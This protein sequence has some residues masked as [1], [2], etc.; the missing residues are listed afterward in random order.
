MDQE[1]FQGRDIVESSFSDCHR[2]TV[3]VKKIYF[4]KQEPRIKHWSNYKM[5]NTQHF[6]QHVFANL[7]KGNAQIIN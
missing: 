6:R 3:S 2:M 7:K 5:F 4:K 1:S